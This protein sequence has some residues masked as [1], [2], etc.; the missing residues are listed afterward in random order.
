MTRGTVLGP[1]GPNGAGKTT[2]VRVLTTLLQAD[3]G[4]ASVLGL[5]VIEDAAEL[6]QG[7]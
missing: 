7:A 1:L 4:T 2:F 6:R 5:D 3:G